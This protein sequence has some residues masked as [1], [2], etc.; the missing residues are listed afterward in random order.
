MSRLLVFIT[1][2]GEIPALG[3]FPEP[4]ITFA[5]S[6]DLPLL[7]PTKEYPVANTCSNS[8]RL[9][10]VQTYDLFLRNM[11]AALEMATTFSAA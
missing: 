4:Q 11:T 6:E 9:P 7:D 5:H 8:I 2:L 10:I 1:G 3:F